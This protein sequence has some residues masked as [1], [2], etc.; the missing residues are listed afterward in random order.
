MATYLYIMK[1]IV[2]VRNSDK[3]ILKEVILSVPFTIGTF[4]VNF[5]EVGFLVD[6]YCLSEKPHTAKT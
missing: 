1:L 3:L 2:C 5:L 6:A 4:F